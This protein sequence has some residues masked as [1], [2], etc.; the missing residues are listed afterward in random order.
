[1]VVWN[2][3]EHTLQLISAEFR[4]LSLKIVVREKNSGCIG[5]IAYIFT[6]Q[7]FSWLQNGQLNIWSKGSIARRLGGGFRF[8]F[9]RPM[10]NWF[11]FNRKN[12]LSACVYFFWTSN[13]AHFERKESH[14]FLTFFEIWAV[15][16]DSNNLRT[17]PVASSQYRFAIW[18]E[19][20]CALLR[21][22][23]NTSF[24]LQ[25][26]KPRKQNCD[27]RLQNRWDLVTLNWFQGFYFP[28]I[29]E[30]NKEGPESEYG[31]RHYQLDWQEK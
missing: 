2:R 3:S 25:G 20:T 31:W 19:L 8:D 29:L 26:W 30:R 22:S 5:E 1:M 11:L 13:H 6:S 21:T 7:L 27:R 24:V 14:W 28:E 4:D 12:C 18:Q 10:L 9:L 16:S 15:N 23:F 17:V